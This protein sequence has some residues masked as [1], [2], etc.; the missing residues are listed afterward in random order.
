MF[1]LIGD[2]LEHIN[3]LERLTERFYTNKTI[4]NTD[5]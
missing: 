2:T 4:E 1:A 5:N 3:F